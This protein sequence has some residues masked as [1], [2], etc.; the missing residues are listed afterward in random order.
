MKLFDFVYPK[1]PTPKD[2]LLSLIRLPK[3][4]SNILRTHFL[5]LLPLVLTQ[6]LQRFQDVVDNRFI[7]SLGT[8]ALEIHNVQFNLYFI[9][10]EIGL[11]AAISALIFWRRKE[12]IGKQGFILKLHLYMPIAISAISAAIIYFFLDNLA[13]HFSIAESFKGTAR[14]Y[15]ILGLVNLVFRSIQ[16][17]LSAILIACDHRIKCLVL[18]GGILL[19]KIILGWTAIHYFWNSQTDPA[20]IL[21]PMIILDVGAIVILL[22]G[23]IV[24]IRW[25]SSFVDGWGR[26]DLRSILKVWPGELGIAAVN[27]A[28]G[29][30]FGFQIAMVTTS[31]GFFVTY[32]LALH[33]TYILALPVIAGMQIAVRDASAEQSNVLGT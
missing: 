28:A 22:L 6:L 17:P 33:F 2:V 12:C 11:A 15:W 3:A 32:Q 5:I 29:I 31:P 24:G 26:M 21:T 13:N 30:I 9:A 19:G 7:S 8:Q 4:F 23:S 27:S 16:I 1:I 18:G 14:I 25:I 10:Q 20:S